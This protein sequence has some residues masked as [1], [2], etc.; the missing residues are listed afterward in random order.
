MR[1]PEPACSLFGLASLEL[2]PFY[3]RGAAAFFFCFTLG[4]E[5]DETSGQQRKQANN[6]NSI[7]SHLGSNAWWGQLIH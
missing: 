3:L 1:R 5:A 6:S 4:T 2:L 7:R